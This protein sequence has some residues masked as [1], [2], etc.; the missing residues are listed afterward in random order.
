[1]VV[2]KPAGMLTHAAPGSDGPTLVDVLRGRV[3]GGDPEARGI[4]HRLDRETSG[5]LVVARD[6][7]TS[8]KLQSL[9]RRRQSAASTPPWCAGDRRRAPAGSRRP[10]GA[11]GDI[12]RG[13]RPRPTCPRGG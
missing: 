10:S 7:T 5:L 1:M 8:V 6:E 13:C 12:R 4:V 11:T 3:G 2:D 9:L